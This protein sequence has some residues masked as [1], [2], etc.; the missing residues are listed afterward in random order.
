MAFRFDRV[1]LLLPRLLIFSLSSSSSHDHSAALLA[2][3]FQFHFIH[4]QPLGLP[5]SSFGVRLNSTQSG[6]SFSPCHFTHYPPKNSARER[7]NEKWEGQKAKKKR[8]T[9]TINKSPVSR[10]KANNRL[11]N[12]KWYTIERAHYDDAFVEW[13]QCEKIR[14]KENRFN[15]WNSLNWISWDFFVCSVVGD[16]QRLYLRLTGSVSAKFWSAAKLDECQTK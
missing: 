16:G 14:N 1:L 9:K 6:F 10:M 7:S 13:S 11:K 15:F 8:E 3:P 12:W 4:I 2:S 5:F